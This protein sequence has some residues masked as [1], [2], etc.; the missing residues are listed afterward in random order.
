MVDKEVLEELRKIRKEI[1]CIG[2]LALILLIVIIA[3]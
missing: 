3:K 2:M 1:I